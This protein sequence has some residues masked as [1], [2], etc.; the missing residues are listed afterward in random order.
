MNKLGFGFLRLPLKE[1]GTPEEYDWASISKMVDAYLALGGRVFDTCYTYLDGHSEEA[2]R[3]CVAERIPRNRYILVEKLP[4]Y[5]CKTYEDCERYFNEELE[6]CG[7]DRF[8][9]FMIHW[10]NPENYAKAEQTD[11]FHFL[12]EKKA[13]GQ[14]GRIG[15]SYHGSAGLLDKI[16]TAHP[17]T[18]VVLLQINYLD[19]EA[20]GIESRLCYE[21]ALRHGK[22]IFVMEP[23]KGG[24]LAKIPQEAESLLKAVHPD[25]T[26]AD[27]A[28]RFVQSLPG[29]EIC[30]SGMNT[31]EQVEANMRQF[32]PLNEQEIRVLFSARDL[33]R[34]GTKVPCTGCRYCVAHCP[35]NI[36]IPDVFRLYNEISRFPEEGW[37]IRPVYAEQTAAGGK[38]S[39]CIACG[40]C[41]AHCPQNIEI[42]EKMKEAA[43]ALE[44]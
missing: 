29:V 5:Y 19:W 11:Q 26:P 3:R 20:P 40:A 27:W 18:D 7:V 31:L 24:T 14:A 43:A 41:A 8:D 15:F 2:V 37:K 10:L 34:S 17:E 36:Q 9:I 35:G 4:G 23:V 33:I 30:L 42:P 16:L 6:R 12:R 28:L 13:A 21:T 38:A 22:K 39:D 32:E 25:W 1:G 44:R